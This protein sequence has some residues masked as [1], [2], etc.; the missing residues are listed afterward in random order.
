[1]DTIPGV[2]TGMLINHDAMPHRDAP[3]R[4][5]SATLNVGAFISQFVPKEFKRLHPTG[6]STE[7]L[8]EGGKGTVH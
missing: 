3:A 7:A 5:M 2:G 1:M 8:N 6:I 4:S